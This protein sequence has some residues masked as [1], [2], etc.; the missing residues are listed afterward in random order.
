MKQMKRMKSK[1]AQ[2]FTLIELMI[3]VAIIGILAAVAIPSYQAYVAESYGATAMKGA[4]PYISQAQVCI[5][6]GVGCAELA[7]SAAADANGTVVLA[8][9]SRGSTNGTV[10]YTEGQANCVLTGTLTSTGIAFAAA[11]GAGGASTDAQCQNG[12]NVAP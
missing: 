5:E 1:G 7:A 3:V 9:V 10:T 6:T 2:G 11:A 4:G 12:A 8:G